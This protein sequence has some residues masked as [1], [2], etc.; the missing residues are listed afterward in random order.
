M[1]GVIHLL[2]PLAMAYGSH[3]SVKLAARPQPLAQTAAAARSRHEKLLACR[4][5]RDAKAP[6]PLS[7]PFPNSHRAQKSCLWCCGPRSAELGGA[8]GG[9][10]WIFPRC[11][12]DADGRDE[13]Q[14][15]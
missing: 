1:D 8:Y 4:C 12:V 10:W 5:S 13:K 11:P 2:T 3:L 9:A 14:Q 15:L 6:A 7:L